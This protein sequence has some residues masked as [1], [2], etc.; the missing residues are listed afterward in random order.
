MNFKSRFRL[1]RA[2][3]GLGKF[4]SRLPKKEV[5]HPKRKSRPP[6]TMFRVVNERKRGAIQHTGVN[7]N[8]L[9]RMVM[10]KKRLLRPKERIQTRGR[11]HIATA[12]RRL[13]SARNE[14][15]NPPIHSRTRTGGSQRF[16]STGHT[17]LEVSGGALEFFFENFLLFPVIYNHFPGKF[18]HLFL[19]LILLNIMYTRKGAG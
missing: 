3:C 6:R 10:S 7:R 18:S 14:V 5:D 19:L 12:F 8:K 4:L 2:S 13:R 1:A 11:T 16:G 9:Q 17:S 15:A